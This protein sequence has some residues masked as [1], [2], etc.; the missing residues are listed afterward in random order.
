MMKYSAVDR[1]HLTLSNV[2]IKARNCHL[3]LV[4]N[5][6]KNNPKRKTRTRI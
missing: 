3:Y 1:D 4:L 5:K 2:L 6:R